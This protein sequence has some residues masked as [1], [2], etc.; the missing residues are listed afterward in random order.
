MA[1]H[2][3]EWSLIIPVKRLEVAKSRI[4]LPA[5]DR[6]DLAL[7]MA[8]D[9]MAAAVAC[10]M[11]A[12][13]VVVTDDARAVAALTATGVTVVAD[14]PD[15]GL[16]PALRHG[17]AAAAGG[18][19]VAVSAD[20]P[21]LTAADLTTVLVAAGSHARGVVADESGTGTTVLTAASEAEFVPSF[22]AAS[23]R[24]HL[25]NGSVDLTPFARPSVRRD[26]DTLAGLR[27]AVGMGVGEATQR[28]VARLAGLLG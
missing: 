5:A 14:A 4:A 6:A 7:A 26:V 8:V 19:I 22:G 16:N 9:T 18:R 27:D 10:A 15:A 2:N 20:L 21:A 1:A 11:V 3:D 25:C 17:A 23:F 12:R 13:V 28:V 24:A